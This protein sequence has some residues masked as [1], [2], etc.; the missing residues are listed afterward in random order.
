[1][2]FKKASWIIMSKLYNCR[3]QFEFKTD[4]LLLFLRLKESCSD[5]KE[6]AVSGN[7]CGHSGITNMMSLESNR[8]SSF[9][10]RM[11]S[12]MFVQK[13]KH[14]APWDPNAHLSLSLF[15]TH[16]LTHTHTHS[17]THT[18]PHTNT[19]AH[20]HTHS[21]THTPKHTDTHS[22]THTQTTHTAKQNKHT[23]HTHRQVARRR[24]SDTP[25]Q[26]GRL[27]ATCPYILRS[28]KV[29]LANYF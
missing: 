5:L 28:D 7:W 17:L 20:T 10:V 18:H 26:T 11:T 27:K 12:R 25:T 23:T 24:P 15:Y 6:D 9:I 8:I 14:L 3:P 29:L 2:P 1:M 19:H 22:L 16:S 21:L 4:L 13:Y